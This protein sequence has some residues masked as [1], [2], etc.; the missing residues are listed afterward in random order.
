MAATHELSI[1]DSL[2]GFL[3]DLDPWGVSD[4]KVDSAYILF[5]VQVTILFT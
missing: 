3:R 5:T 2:L 4:T 1:S